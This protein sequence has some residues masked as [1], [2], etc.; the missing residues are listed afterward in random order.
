MELKLFDES[1]QITT[2]TIPKAL[3]DVQ[4]LWMNMEFKFRCFKDSRDKEINKLKHD[5]FASKLIFLSISIY[6]RLATPIKES[7]FALFLR[8]C[9]C[10]M[11][12]E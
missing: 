1:F 4:A 7:P 3:H 11:T 9:S 5:L 6:K 10:D 8:K 2:K 12:E